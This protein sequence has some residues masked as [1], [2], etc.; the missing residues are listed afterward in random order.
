MDVFA[1]HLTVFLKAWSGTFG[2]WFVE[3]SY[4]GRSVLWDAVGRPE[5][6]RRALR[7]RDIVLGPHE[8][9]VTA[10]T[11]EITSADGLAFVQATGGIQQRV[12]DVWFANSVTLEFDMRGDAARLRNASEARRL[13][14]DGVEAFRPDWAALMPKNEIAMRPTDFVEGRPIVG[15]VTYLSAAFSLSKHLVSFGGRLDYLPDGGAV[16]TAV[17]DEF[18]EQSVGQRQAYDRART[19]LSASGA[20]VPFREYAL[21]T[22]PSR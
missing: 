19:E 6:L 5:A 18:D 21:R 14:R 4:R 9:K 8:V 11:A 3:G 20:L 17:T 10:Y 22:R 15:W 16:I 1:S 7:E 13:L 2:G 12:G